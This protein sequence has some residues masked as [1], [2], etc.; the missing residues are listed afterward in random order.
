[1]KKVTKVV[2]IISIIILAILLSYVVK[3]VID[4]NSHKPMI[5]TSENWNEHI[6][7]RERMLDSLNSQYNLES[8]TYEQIEQL[9]GTNGVVEGRI[10]IS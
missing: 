9:L 1:M 3:I 2:V 10:K 6:C 8:M 7:Q 5:F 4:N